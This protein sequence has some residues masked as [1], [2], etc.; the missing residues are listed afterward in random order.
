MPNLYNNFSYLCRMLKLLKSTKKYLSNI[1]VE[2]AEFCNK[3][4]NYKDKNCT[5]YTNLEL[6]IHLSIK[7]VLH[8]FPDG[9]I[10]DQVCFFIN[11]NWY[12]FPYHVLIIC[13]F[14]NTDY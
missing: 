14:R 8:M 7:E 9:F 1:S 2:Q 10:D 12:L 6:A 3:L 5:A 13:V 4:F 11:L